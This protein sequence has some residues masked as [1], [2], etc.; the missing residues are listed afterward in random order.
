MKSNLMKMYELRIQLLG[1]AD[2][3]FFKLVLQ[4]SLLY[5]TAF[6]FSRKESSNVIKLS[7]SI[8]KKDYTRNLE[9]K[10]TR[11]LDRLL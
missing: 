8:K 1:C 6:N 3:L 10:N 4:S 7:Y 5:T 9:K 11:N 2:N